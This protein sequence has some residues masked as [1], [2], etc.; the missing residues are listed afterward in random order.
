MKKL[1]TDMLY[2]LLSLLLCTLAIPA[3]AQQYSLKGRI[4]DG[5]TG[6]NTGFAIVVIKEAGIVVNA[7]A[8]NYYAILPQAGTYTV[9]VQ[10]QGLQTVTATVTVNGNVTRDFTL[11]PFASRGRGVV[12]K[13]ER[14][15]QK[16]SRRTMKVDEIKE[17]PASF[18]DS[19]NALTSLP[20]VIRSS[21]GGFFGPLV[22]R[23]ADPI[24]NRYY[25][26]GMPIDNPLHFGG[27]HS[28]IANDL[29]SEID[30]YASS[31]TSDFGGP[32]AAV[33]NINTIDEVDEFGGWSDVGLISAAALIKSPITK[34]VIN[35][36]GE[37]KEEN[38]GYLIVSGRVG[39]LSL[40]I[41]PIYELMN[42]EK[43]DLLPEYWD[44]QVKAKY[45]LDSRNSVTV[46]C[47]GSVDYWRVIVDEDD[48]KREEGSDPYF[49][50]IDMKYDQ[51]FHNQG[52]Y[53]TFDN[54]KVKNTMM[55]YSSWSYTH[56]YFDSASLPAGHWLKGITIDTVP[57]ILG[58][59]DNFKW[60]WSEG[61][62]ELRGGI[63]SSW[64]HFDAKGDSLRV[65]PAV[66]DPMDPG[67]FDVIPFDLNFTNLVMGGYLEQR[68]TPG[69]FVFMPSFRSE[70]LRG[71]GFVTADP[72]GMASCRFESD[73]T[74]S[75][76]G[77]HYS[78]FFQANPYV[79]Q[80]D[81]TYASHGDTLEPEKG[82]HCA[83]GVEQAFTGFTAN[84]EM[85]YNY[86]YDLVEQYEHVEGGQTV[87]GI[88]S[89]K[90]RAYG[91]EFLLKREESGGDG[92]FGWGSYTFTNAER[93]TG[94]P[95]SF[96]PTGDRWIHSGYE[97]KHSLKIV[98]GFRNGRHSLSGRFQLYSSF[99]YTPIINSNPTALD[100]PPADGRYAPVYDIGHPNS[101]HLPF[102][103]QLDL[104]YTHRTGYEWGEVS[105]YIEVINVYGQWFHSKSYNW[106]YDQPYGEDNPKITTDQGG[107]TFL[108][109]FGV[110]VKF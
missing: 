73:T 45:L 19:V 66:T 74:L 33:I 32:L 22:I 89:G 24:Y 52:L 8:G 97:Q 53:Y 109:N 101:K 107:L 90:M 6:R 82:W 83:L 2:S 27:V 43:L 92:F 81:P 18:G 68:F 17:V 88:N 14:V 11:S 108:P 31:Y 37:S 103:H 100:P 29:M 64:Y 36:K 96:D 70:W 56:M 7:A 57:W 65:N 91:F 86:F 55:V 48:I 102:D 84:I 42:D 46:L 41:P 49:S 51:Q 26:D 58:A 106:R 5:S 69:P 16:V 80:Q 15:I 59:K 25:I 95:V 105:W 35:E 50:D 12:I 87:P 71:T 34:K 77:G 28:V 104:R 30:L 39:Y 4:I 10:S 62:A 94:L 60:A 1:K 61:L 23:G 98:S 3:Y 72:R 79:F 9:Q 38:T 13:G 20:G 54:V 40:L 21:P 85:F 63:E 78:S 47:L 99:P 76:A 110:E 75:I 44:Y 67:A 93:K